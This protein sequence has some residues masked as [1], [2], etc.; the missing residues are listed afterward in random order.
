MYNKY[1][2]SLLKPKAYK[3]AKGTGSRAEISI[4]AGKSKTLAGSADV[5]QG[6]WSPR[7]ELAAIQKSAGLSTIRR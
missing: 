2:C 4:L 7:L 5:S 6:K 1:R 3:G